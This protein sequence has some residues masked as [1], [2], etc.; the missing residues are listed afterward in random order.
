[1]SDLSKTTKQ[2]DFAESFRAIVGAKVKQ[3]SH[4]RSK[5]VGAS[6]VFGCLRR[7]WFAKFKPE[8]ADPEMAP[9][10]AAARGNLIEDHYVV[11]IIREMFGDAKV[12]FLG[13][14]Q[15]TLVSGYS[16]ATP[17]GLVFPTRQDLLAKYGVP[18]IGSDCFALEIKSFD[19]RM[20][21]HE[22]KVVHRGQIITQMGL[23]NEQTNH[24]PQWG[25]ILYVNAADLFDV[26]PFVIEYSPA[27]YGVSKTRAELVFNTTDPYALKAEGVHTD[28]CR[29]CPFQTACKDAEL[30]RFPRSKKRAVLSPADKEALS[31]LVTARQSAVNAE[32]K[33][34]AEKSQVNEDIKRM[35]NA[36]GTTKAEVEGFSLSYSKMD[37]RETLDQ[38]A[39]E[40]DGIDL[41]KYKKTNNGFTRLQVTEK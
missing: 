25:V 1:L 13:E 24:K 28:A 20:N 16:S 8:L 7:S 31:G 17:D 36:L 41:E 40:R 27:I 35:L 32:K 37:G 12:L 30:G 11:P 14:D 18:D 33:A 5:T 15:R 22:E 9:G 29:Y 4:D 34:K 3:F 39:M 10:G 38:D 19:P 21:I 6:E 2:F 26:R 23:F